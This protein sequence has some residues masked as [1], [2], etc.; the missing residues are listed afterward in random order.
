MSCSLTR[1]QNSGHAAALGRDLPVRTGIDKIFFR[2]HSVH[3]MFR[4]VGYS[5]R[6]FDFCKVAGASE[7]AWLKLGPT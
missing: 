2:E 5:S 7:G 4:G 3:V 1:W 6:R